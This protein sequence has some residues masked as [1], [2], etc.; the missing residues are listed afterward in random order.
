MSLQ[1]S[2]EKV[3]RTRN[4]RVEEGNSKYHESM[5][6]HINSELSSHNLTHIDQASIYSK[7]KH[8]RLQRK[9]D[10]LSQPCICATGW[11]CTKAAISRTNKHTMEQGGDSPHGRQTAQHQSSLLGSGTGRGDLRRNPEAS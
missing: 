3:T 1:M 9:L 2:L 4:I 10:H 6:I 8:G 7:T 5:T 11:N